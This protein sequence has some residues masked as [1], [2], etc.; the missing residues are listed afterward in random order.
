MGSRD[1]V[2][3]ML[4]RYGELGVSEIVLPVVHPYDLEGLA[5][6]SGALP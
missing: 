3:E 4:G 5:R 1:F 6:L 2:Q